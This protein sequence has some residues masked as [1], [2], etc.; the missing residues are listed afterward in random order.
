MSLHNPLRE[1]GKTGRQKKR[2]EKDFAG[3]DRV[4]A[5]QS[6][7]PP[8]ASLRKAEDG[9][10]SSVKERGGGRAKLAAGGE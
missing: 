8:E 6:L 2:K 4:A 5:T 1:Q 3:D 7:F 10:S 9:Q